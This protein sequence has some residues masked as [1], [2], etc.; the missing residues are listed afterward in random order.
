[1]KRLLLSIPILIILLFAGNAWGAPCTRTVCASGC[2]HTTVKA[3]VDYVEASCSSGSTINI[4]AGNY[5]SANDYALLDHANH[6]N[7]TINGAGRTSTVL[8]PSG[9]NV[10][11]TTQSITVNISNMTLN[12]SGANRAISNFGS[13]AEPTINLTDVDLQVSDGTAGNIANLILSDGGT[14]NSTRSRFFYSP[15]TSNWRNV[16]RLMDTAAGNFN[17]NMFMVTGNSKLSQGLSIESSGAVNFNNCIFADNYGYAIAFSGAGAYSVKNSILAGNIYNATDYVINT[18]NKNV[19]LSNN[20]VIANPWDGDARW[21]SG[22]YTDGGGNLLTSVNPKFT[23]MPRVGFILPRIDDVGN[24]STSGYAY[25]QTVES[26]LSAKGFTGTYMVNTTSNTAPCDASCQAGL[27]SLV[28]GGVWEVGSHSYTH[29][30]LTLTG[31]IFD[32]TKAAETITI[33]RTAGTI[34]LS[35]G[36]SVTGF[37]AKT[38]NAIKTELEGL[39]ATVTGATLFSAT[40]GT[41]QKLCGLALGEVIDAGAAVNVINLKTDD[42]GSAGV[43]PAGGYYKSEIYDQMA[44]LNSVIT[45]TDP[46]TGATYTARTFGFPYN[47]SSA[48]ARLAT[49]YSG[50]IAAGSGK[51]GGAGNITD[52]PASI[53]IDIYAI[54]NLGGSTYL[55]GSN[56]ANTR[57][58]ARALA[59][60]A[61]H[62]GLVIGILCHSTTECSADTWTYAVDEWNSYGTQLKVLSHQQFRDYIANVAN[63]WTD[64]TDGTYSR[65][66]TN[67]TGNYAL[68]VGSPAINAGTPVTGIHDVPCT[69]FGGRNCRDSNPDIGAYNSLQNVILGSGPVWPISGGGSLWTLQ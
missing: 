32:V 23:T 3:A 6:D 42:V 52:I 27:V 54:V 48:D 57:F 7:I 67:G 20:L 59:F 5:T 38:L 46:Q 66:Y 69:D 13:S 8:K 55:Q 28:A 34:T 64:D 9:A 16:I 41:D 18:N 22:T 58:N 47:R 26:I 61:A 65:T 49:I 25:A 53:D 40:C 30:D 17:Y 33:D 43:P 50:Y 15:D 37:K 24:G 29:S 12:S 31:K 19:T 62:T 39:G 45:G 63:G 10:V 51:I 11:Q 36:G 56:E 21:V 1:M 2:D 14:I 60:A 68:Q 44:W 35:G 4:G